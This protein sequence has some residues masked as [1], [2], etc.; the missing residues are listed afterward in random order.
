MYIGGVQFTENQSFI[1][2]VFL[3]L[4]SATA[5]TTTGCH[6]FVGTAFNVPQFAPNVSVSDFVL[7]LTRRIQ[8]L[9]LESESSVVVTFVP[10]G[11]VNGCVVSITTLSLQ[12]PN[13]TT[14]S[15]RTH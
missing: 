15:S 3:N 10:K 8:D 1:L 4:P 11:L 12:Y 13:V 7:P 9:E 6:E 2:D 14:S 5:D